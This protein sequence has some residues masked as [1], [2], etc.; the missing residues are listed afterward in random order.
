MLSSRNFPRSLIVSWKRPQNFSV[1][2]C[3]YMLDD[4][5]FQGRNPQWTLPS[6][7]FLYVQSSRR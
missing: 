7:F 1:K 5:A 2:R 6:I 3:I 4:L